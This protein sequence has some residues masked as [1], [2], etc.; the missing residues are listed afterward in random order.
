MV[1]VKRALISV[2]DKKGIVDFAK[3]LYNL[4][5][6]IISTGGTKE[7]LNKAKIP[8]YSISEY[9][10]ADEMLDGRVKTLHPKIYAGILAIRDNKRHLQQLKKEGIDLI[11]MVVINLYPFE[12]IISCKNSN[13]EVIIENIDIGGPTL[14][15]AAAK[16]YRYVAAVSSPSQYQSILKEL[17][18][19]NNR[20]S[21]ETLIKLSIQTF[22]YTYKYDE[23]IYRYLKENIRPTISKEKHL[24]EFSFAQEIDLKFRKI[25]DLRYGENPHQKGAFYKDDKITEPSITCTRQL[26]GKEL[27]FNNIMDLDSVLEVIK[28]FDKPCACIIKHTNPCGVAEAKRLSQAYRKALECDPLSAFGSVVGL[29]RV[30]DEETASLMHK[31]FVEC[32]LA[33]GYTDSALKILKRKKNIRILDIP[34]LNKSGIDVDIRK[35]TGGLLL[36]EKDAVEID[37]RRLK[38]VTKKK[39]TRKQMDSLLFAWKVCKYIKSNAI[40]L[41]RGHQTVGIGAGQPSRIDSVIIAT[42]KAGKRSKGSVLASDGFFPKEDAIR[43]AH[44]AGIRAIIQPGG[45]IKDRDIIEE[46]DRLKISMVFTGVRHFRH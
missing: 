6:E 23:I 35:V 4:G 22:N 29:N 14:L 33:C 3:G 16:N 15:R 5:I 39:P 40:V 12:D 32:V 38:I 34:S 19:N 46:A 7:I 2:S 9:I 17:K 25:Q 45:S 27:S 11:D 20:L 42:R 18:E 36:Q 21:D 30:V 13:L 43:V 37:S 1:R 44:K 10:G 8:A 26:H 31:E 41:A 28:I 24:D